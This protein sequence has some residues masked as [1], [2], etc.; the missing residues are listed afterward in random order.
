MDKP[1]VTILIPQPYKWTKPG[2]QPGFAGSS[3]P[4]TVAD[5]LRR[6]SG[7]LAHICTLPPCLCY[8]DFIFEF[9]VP[10][11]YTYIYI[12]Y[13]IKLYILIRTPAMKKKLRAADPPRL[14]NT[15]YHFQQSISAGY[16]DQLHLRHL[17][18]PSQCR[19]SNFVKGFHH[20][21]VW[22]KKLCCCVSCAYIIL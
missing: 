1:Y 11:Y 22:Q 17:W 20:V 8:P 3:P 19:Y 7:G 6:V 4:S 5:I 9:E 16:P 2:I 12:Y 13:I 18:H 10:K 14:S 21:T 15:T